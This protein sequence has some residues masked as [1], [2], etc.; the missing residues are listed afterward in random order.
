M[1]LTQYLIR[2]FVVVVTLYFPPHIPYVYFVCIRAFGTEQNSI[3][4]QSLGAPLLLP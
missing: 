1:I 3:V 4:V 2:F